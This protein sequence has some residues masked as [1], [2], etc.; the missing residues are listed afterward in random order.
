[1]FDEILSLQLI[2]VKLGGRVVS[3]EIE[4]TSS[5]G[6]T[7]TESTAGFFNFPVCDIL[8]PLA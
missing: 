5:M 6:R 2:T 8:L 7:K 1:M 4:S 3:L